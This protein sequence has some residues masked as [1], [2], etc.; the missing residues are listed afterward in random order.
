MTRLRHDI[1]H[2]S[3]RDKQERDER[4]PQRVRGHAP[5]HGLLS[6]SRQSDVRPLDCNRKE[7]APHTGFRAA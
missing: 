1:R 5:A 7:P 4:P 6:A 2:I 3:A